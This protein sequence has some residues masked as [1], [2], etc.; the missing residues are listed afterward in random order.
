LRYTLQQQRERSCDSDGAAVAVYA[1]PSDDADALSLRDF[2]ADSVP[3]T[4]A[5]A[6]ER[7]E[8]QKSIFAQIASPISVPARAGEKKRSWDSS[9]NSSDDEC[10]AAWKAPALAKLF[11]KSEDDVFIVELCRKRA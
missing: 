8:F 2:L 7:A 9:S 1:P 11:G 6:A 5:D 4:V 10:A 3:S